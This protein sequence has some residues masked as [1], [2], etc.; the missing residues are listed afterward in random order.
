MKLERILLSLLLL[1]TLTGPGSVQAQLS[2]T[3]AV[4]SAGELFR[5]FFPIAPKTSPQHSLQLGFIPSVASGSTALSRSETEH[6]KRLLLSSTLAITFA[7][8]AAFCQQSPQQPANDATTTQQQ[9]AGPHHGRHHNFDPHKAALHLGKRLKLS[10]DQTA[11]LEPILA[12]QQQKMASLRS[13]TSLSRDQ[14]RQQF[15]AI[16]QDTKSQLATVL[17]PDQLQQY[18]SMRHG[19]GHRPH[20]QG[21]APNPPSAS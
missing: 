21:D 6:M 5:R 11:K 7:A 17:T 1:F 2:T 3:S 14:R 10:D 18:E 12:A 9:P 13:D 20:Q 4:G 16:Q 15:Q 8:T 19:H